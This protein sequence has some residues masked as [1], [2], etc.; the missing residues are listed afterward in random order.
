M[1][2]LRNATGLRNCTVQG[3]NGVLSADNAYGTKRPTAGAYASLDPGWG[4]DDTRVWITTRSPYVQNVTTFGTGCVGL[5]VDGNLHNGGNDS[6]VANDFTQVLSD[7]IGAWVRNNGRAELVSVFTYYCGIGYFAEDGG[8]IR[9]TNGNNSYGNFGAIA[10]GVDLTETPATALV[11]NRNQQAIVSSTFAGEFNDE[12]QAF[13]YKNAG[14][15]YRTANA[16]ILGAGIGATVQFEDFRDDAMHEVLLKDISTGIGQLIGGSGYSVAQNNAQVNLTPGGDAYSITLASND[17]NEE[18]DYL[19]K[20]LLITGGTGTGQYGYVTSYDTLTKVVTISRESDDQPGWDHIVPGTPL[21]EV[22]DTTTFYRIEPRPI[23]SA[24]E[25]RTT[26]ANI[27]ASTNW[28][29]IVY[30]ETYRV[31][32]NVSVEYVEEDIDPVLVNEFVPRF[33]VIKNGRDYQLTLI[34]GGVGFAVNDTLTILGTAV[35]GQT[36]INDI[37]ITVTAVSEDSTNPVTEFEHTGL[38]ASGRFVATTLAGFIGTYSADGQTWPD[39]F[40]FPSFGD[41][42][43][44]AAVTEPGASQLASNVRFVA[45]RRNSNVAASSLDG[46]TWT[47][48]TMPA[49]RQWSAVCYGEGKFVALSANNNNFAYSTNGTTW[50][51][52]LMPTFG[53][54]S[55]NE[56]VDICYGRNQFVAIANSNNVCATSPDGITWTIRIMDVIDDEGALVH[57]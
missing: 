55:T 44:I 57:T 14:A 45:I 46:I 40:N 41:W 26:V 36:P 8:I 53:D 37:T 47:A 4:P 7:G 27:P 34:S 54:S 48:R 11:N 12:I 10:D 19:G 21:R 29:N 15:N 2:Y 16:A 31:F 39:V 42:A 20:R 30:G 25:F 6:I 43:N 22:F 56:W 28:A 13:E 3:L 24:P 51:L 50:T 35:G 23:F 33:N 1:F 32:N 17:D 18:R 38:G 9:A 52:G 49:S 5:K